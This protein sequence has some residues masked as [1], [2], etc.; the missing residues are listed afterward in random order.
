[1]GKTEIEW[2][3]YSVNPIRARFEDHVGHYCQKIS[4]G[5]AN[6]YSSRIQARLQMPEF[7]KGQNNPYVKT[8]F[9]P[10]KLHEVS[11]RRKPTK[12]FWCDMTDIFGRWVPDGWIDEC[13]R[14]MVATPQHIH[15]I[16]T[17]RAE[18]MNMYIS[19]LPDVW[20]GNVRPGWPLPN[21]WLG[22]SVEDQATADERIPLLLQTPA[23]VRFVSLEPM[24]G[25]VD[26][27]KTPALEATTCTCVNPYK[28]KQCDK[29]SCHERGSVGAIDWVIV[30]GE[31]GPKA[32]QCNLAWIRST[33]NQCKSAGVPCFVKQLGTYPVT[34]TEYVDGG[35]TD[36]GVWRVELSDHKGGDLDEWPA[37]LKV[38]E[39]PNV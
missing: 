16:L 30:G 31:S 24:L 6:C 34:S 2:T 25:P 13:F 39:F 22:V 18:R 9:D 21:V 17:K 8:W 28:T 29:Q 38:R 1:M 33:V 12:F 26:L 19:S 15:Q 11:R 23:T 14:T 32:R 37:D 10:H 5:C 36:G 27:R 3:E 4:A 7:A 35:K 20:A